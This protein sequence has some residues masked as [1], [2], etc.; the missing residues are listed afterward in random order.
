M[1]TPYLY[2]DFNDGFD[3]M[4][5]ASYFLTIYYILDTRYC[6]HPHILSIS[7]L[8][9]LCISNLFIFKVSVISPASMVNS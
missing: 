9:L 7:S 5:P 2:F 8:Y 4:L 1:S 6:F 3:L